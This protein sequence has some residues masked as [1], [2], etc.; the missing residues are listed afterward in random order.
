VDLAQAERLL[1][2]YENVGTEALVGATNG[3]ET[4][5]S[6]FGRAAHS[7][8]CYAVSGNASQV[9]MVD[10]GDLVSNAGNLLQKSGPAM[11]EA[12]DSAVLY[13]IKG[14]YRSKATGLACY[15]PYI[16]P[17]QTQQ[18][19]A[20]LGT[21]NSF[22]YFYEYSVNGK[23]SQE[24]LDYLAALENAV[25]LEPVSTPEE[26]PA[27]TQLDDFPLAVDP[28]MFGWMLD[29]G[30]QQVQSIA[31]VQ[32]SIAYLLEDGSGMILLGSNYDYAQDWDNGIFT[33]TWEG[34]W[35]VWGGNLMCSYVSESTSFMVGKKTV[36]YEIVNCPMLLNGEPYELRVVYVEEFYE[37][38]TDGVVERYTKV[39][40][41]YKP[42]SGWVEAFGEDFVGSG[43]E[44]SANAAQ[45]GVSTNTLD[46]E[47]SDSVAGTDD[48]ASVLS[49]PTREQRT[50]EQGDVIEPLFFY[51]PMDG[52]SEPKLKPYGKFTVGPD[53]PFDI[54]DV[55]SG[56]YAVMF[57]M[58][59][60]SGNLY[61][62]EVQFYEHD[63]DYIQMLAHE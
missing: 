47:E 59:D 14:P 37:G 52:G 21:S 58:T 62:S 54:E 45:P 2:A 55:G 48:G 1:Q 28:D 49:A 16:A 25:V 20:E 24:G 61:Y 44:S 7:S 50:I 26:L 12:I 38:G 56:T 5:I 36:N 10:L 18:L 31:D 33:D 8:E 4:Y 27:T 22:S 32:T 57:Q 11:L 13:Q 35:D 51:I 42:G 19:F 3:Q 15:Y 30:P 34:Y 39:L 46:G 41:A 43:S 6:E 60:Y 29:L 9:D 53:T 40:G 17:Q 63:G 23:M